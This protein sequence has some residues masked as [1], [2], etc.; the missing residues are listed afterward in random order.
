MAALAVAVGLSALAIGAILSTALLIGPAA[1]ALRLTRR[2]SWALFTAC[3]VGVGVTWLG[4][5]MAYD[6]YHWGSSHRG[7]PVS[8]FIVFLVFALYLV[9]GVPGLRSSRRTN[10]DGP[11]EGVGRSLGR[12]ARDGAP[13]PSE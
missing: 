8:F 13:G 3:I 11:L 4:V 12:P 1:T 6:S 7:L 5:L 10:G 9:S 2:F